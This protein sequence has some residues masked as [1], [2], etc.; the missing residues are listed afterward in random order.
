MKKIKW[1]VLGTGRIADTFAAALA[2]CDEA[3]LTAVASRSVEK[4]KKFAEKHG[5]LKAFGSYEE[6][7]RQGGTDVVYIGTPTAC[8]YENAMLCIANGKNVVC[9]KAVAMNAAQVKELFAAA[10]E[11]KLF[12]TEA[13]WMKFRPNFRQALTWFQQGKIGE[14]EM[15]K[16]DF[17]NLVMFDSEDRLFKKELGASALLDMG[18]YPLAL[19]EAFLG[20]PDKIES[21]LHIGRTGVDFDGCAVLKYD[22]AFAQTSFGYS[23]ASKNGCT[24]VGSLG[25]IVFDEW[26]FCSSNVKLYDNMGNLID[27]KDFPN[28]FNGY[29]YEIRGIC[30]SL[31]EGRTECEIVPHESTTAVSEIMDIIL[32]QH[33]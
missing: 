16:A 21:A 26:F 11:K 1:G 6:L 29:E 33:Q 4:A 15:I 9:E 22:R 24:I 19:F 25:S 32:S 10:N 23:A 30:R 12:F 31:Q 3:E 28:E 8:H 14:I 7:C 17:T 27:E 18:I 2:F 20:R 13:M 5:A